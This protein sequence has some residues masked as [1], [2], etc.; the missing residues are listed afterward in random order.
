MEYG[1]PNGKNRSRVI[2]SFMMKL[3]TFWDCLGRGLSARASC[4]KNAAW[5]GYQVRIG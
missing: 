1:K 5:E 4:A 3:M 2:I